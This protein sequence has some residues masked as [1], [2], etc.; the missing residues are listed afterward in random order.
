[1]PRS[2]YPS[3]CPAQLRLG[4]RRLGHAHEAP[5]GRPLVDVGIG[6]AGDRPPPRLVAGQE[7][8]GE[9]QVHPLD[10]LGVGRRVGALRPV[11]AAIRP[12]HALVEAPDARRLALRLRLRAVRQ[13][14]DP[15]HG[16]GEAADGILTVARPVVHPGERARVQGLHQQGADAGDHGAH[17]AVHDPGRAVLGEE[18]G[19][20]A[21]GELA[22][23]RRGA[24]RIARQRREQASAH[25]GDG[26]AR[27]GAG[28][29]PGSC[30]VSS[31][32]WG[33]MPRSA[34]PREYGTRER[35]RPR[36]WVRRGLGSRCR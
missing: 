13:A 16:P 5:R 31:V 7:G 10:E 27:S 9:G 36:R 26:A 25:A 4:V 14:D 17:P 19:V 20:V 35:P 24:V 33:R 18:S 15:A 8:V 23:P 11:D 34:D 30:H 12:L 2:R 21:L 1:M 6:A 32:P 28:P 29:L 22:H 3:I